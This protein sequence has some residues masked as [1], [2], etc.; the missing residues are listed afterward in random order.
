MR[1]KI[2]KEEGKKKKCGSAERTSP[3]IMLSLH[4]S[5]G[6]ST[7][8]IKLMVW[9][10]ACC[11]CFVLFIYLFFFP[12]VFIVFFFFYCVFL[13]RFDWSNDLPA[14]EHRGRT[15]VFGPSF[16]SSASREAAVMMAPIM[17]LRPDYGGGGTAH[18]AHNSAPQ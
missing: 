16:L 9:L 15:S 13:P 8:I 12:N 17:T 3:L 4:N 7:R 5:Q 14:T 18:L 6:E 1:V 2:A 10:F 11:C